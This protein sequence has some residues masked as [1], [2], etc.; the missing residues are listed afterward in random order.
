MNT[1]IHKIVLDVAK[2]EPQLATTIRK[3]D[4]E[5]R[6]FEFSLRANGKQYVITENC[7]AV[8]RAKKPDGT[9]LFNYCSINNSVVTYTLTSQTTAVEGTLACQLEIVSVDGKVLY[10][11]RFNII[12]EDVV[13]SD[14]EIESESE[15]TFITENVARIEAARDQVSEDRKDIDEKT[16]IVENLYNATEESFA[17]A[18]ALSDDANEKLELSIFL[19]ENVSENAQKTEQYMLNAEQYMNSAKSYSKES[20]AVKNHV[21]ESALAAANSAS[22]SKN[23]ASEAKTSEINAGNSATEAAGSASAASSSAIIASEAS[24]SASESASGALS[25][26]AAS[27]SYAI[28]NTNS[29]KYYYEQA[30]GISE[31]LGGA[32]QPHGT[33]AFSDLPPISEVQPGWMYNISDEF[34]TTADFAE[35]AGCVEPAGSNVY[36]TADG[37]WDILAGTPVTGI[38]GNNET[39]Y[40]RGNVNITAENVGAVPEYGD[41]ADNVVKFTSSDDK[42][43]TEYEDVDLLSTG[44]QHKSL[45]TKISS[46]FK[47]IRFFQKRIGTTDISGISD[48]ITGAINTMNQNLTELITGT[49]ATGDTSLTITDSRIKETSIIDIYFENKLLAPTSVTVTDGSIT[50]EIEAQE[51]DTNVGI[52]AL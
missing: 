38:K 10:S 32:I 37:K 7:S 18:K 24:A 52:R 46:M 20:E 12:V 3:G 11:P 42:N 39:V 49:I 1:V 16:A 50:I 34:T 31:G 5:S 27:Q 4:S 41:T 45:L 48:T 17:T 13:Y 35:G 26:A 29:A 8:F 43:P 40:R 25:Y 36:K 23:A 6:I 30:K 47:N 21:D 9:V 33:V 28:G 51:T 44:E 15:M 14:E 22:E 2:S 19:N